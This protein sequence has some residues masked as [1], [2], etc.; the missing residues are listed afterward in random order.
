M[1]YLFDYIY[2][3]ASGDHPLQV[4]NSK[5][6]D[7]MCQRGDFLWQSELSYDGWIA[8]MDGAGNYHH[9]KMKR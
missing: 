4:L 2:T 6:V 8:F 9:F 7:A 1:E 3:D 5:Q